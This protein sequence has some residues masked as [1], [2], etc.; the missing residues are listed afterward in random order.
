MAAVARMLGISPSD[1]VL[2]NQS[3]DTGQKSQFVQGIVQD[4]P[5]TLVTSAIH[6]PRAMRA[7]EQK[8]LRPIPA[9]TEFGDWIRKETNPYRFFPSA[10]ELRK[11]EAALHE[12]LGLFWAN[13]CIGWFI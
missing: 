9:P 8:G 4:D 11:V 2:E 6:M 10:G 1:M 7:F 5:C 13:T 3:K 12:Y